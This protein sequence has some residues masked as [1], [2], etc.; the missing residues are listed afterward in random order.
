LREVPLNLQQFGD[1]LRLA[2]AVRNHLPPIFQARITMLHRDEIESEILN[3]K[4]RIE[5][6]IAT[7][8]YTI[9]LSDLIK[10]IEAKDIK[11]YCQIIERINELHNRH[12]SYLLRR[13]LLARL[14]TAAPGWARAIRQRAIPHEQGN[15][16]GDVHKAWLWRQLNDELEERAEISFDILQL[17]IDQ[18]V[19]ELHQTT[20]EMIETSAWAHQ[21]NRTGLQQKQALNGWVQTMRRIGRGTGRRVPQLQAEARLQMEKC[22]SAVP[23]WIMPLARV[24][25]NYH[26]SQGLF[27][28]VIIDEASQCD[29]MGLI[30]LYLGKKALVVGDHE[31]VSPDAVGQRAEDAQNLIDEYLPGIPNA[32]L[33]DGKLSIYDLGMQSFSGTICLREHFRCVPEIIQFSNDLSYEGK[34]KPLRDSTQNPLSPAVISHHVSDG[35]SIS[36]VNVHEA[37]AVA[38]MVAAATEQPEY[39]GQKFGVISLVGDEQ[40]EEIERILREKITPT[41]YADRQ[42]I[43]GNAAQFQGDERDVMFLSVVNGPDQN[44]PLRIRLEDLFKKRFNV[45]ASRPRNQLWVVHSLQPAIDLKPGDLRRRLIEYAQNPAAQ[46]QTQL[47]E[48]GRVESEFERR[49][50]TALLDAGY[51]V[52]PQWRVGAYRIDLV[53]SG[54]NN[55][56]AVECDG[57]RWCPLEKIPED[58]ERQAILERLGWKFIRI[59]GSEFFRDP[60]KTMRPVFARLESLGIEPERAKESSDQKGEEL[61]DRVMRRAEQLRIEWNGMILGPVQGEVSTNSLA[62]LELDSLPAYNFDD[63]MKREYET[64]EINETNEKF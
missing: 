28:V 16:P 57:D 41:E 36:K 15:P 8:H 7:E 45:A 27:D 11:L 61:S 62:D 14:E 55:R 26:P 17:E 22:R 21:I 48:S 54:Q 23:V 33:Y 4:S 24:V 34:I 60:A 18:R 59:R 40:A 20:A 32:N 50:M 47:K 1:L 51:Q 37:I 13:E 30:A 42:L 52:R 43:C 10:A 38:S 58:M 25:E 5:S 29:V 35:F 53:V 2:D 19:E 12:Q 6:K 39:E 9:L 63:Q 64:N 44:G 46:I 49:V 3:Y 31:Q 56:L